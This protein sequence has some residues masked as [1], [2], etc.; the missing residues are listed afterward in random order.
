MAPLETVPK[1]A[2]IETVVTARPGDTLGYA[3]VSTNDQNP[4]AQR[5]HLIEAGAIRVFADVV[6]GKR[7]LLTH[8]SQPA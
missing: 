8:N 7:F 4:E 1:P 5:A 6:S 2:D 3:R